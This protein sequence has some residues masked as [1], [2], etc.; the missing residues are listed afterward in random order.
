LSGENPH[1][2]Q[3]YSSESQDMSHPI[4]CQ[5][6]ALTGEVGKPHAAIH[7]V[8]YC[9]DCRAYA[10]HLGKGDSVLDALGGTDVVATQ[11]RYVTITRG[12]ENLACMSLSSKGA[13]RWYAKCCN[14]PIANTSRDWRMPFVGLVHTGLKKP[15]E[16][17]FPAVQMH[18]NTGSAK[19]TPPAMGWSKVTAMLGFMPKL[20]LARFTGSY[21]RTPFFTASGAPR[22]E[23]EVLSR[24]QR[25]AAKS[26]A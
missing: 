5:C 21:R 18:L 26:A 11:A 19:G 8:C 15:L 6:G 25:E 16:R 17:S 4:Q 22:V 3:P 10:I 23:V 7:A 14:T 9:K 24:E 12:I 2:D 20:L 1:I 13:L